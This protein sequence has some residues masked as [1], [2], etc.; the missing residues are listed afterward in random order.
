MWLSFIKP[1]PAYFCN[2]LSCTKEYQLRSLGFEKDQIE[3]YDIEQL[4]MA[5]QRIDDCISKPEAFGVFKYKIRSRTFYPS[6]D[7]EAFEIGIL[8]IFYERKQLILERIRLIKNSE[9]KVDNL[10]DLVE[11]L[12]NEEAKAKL[13]SEIDK[14]EAAQFESQKLQAEQNK[15]VIEQS[16]EDE[17]LKSE[18]NK[19]T[20]FKERS[21]IWL[22]FLERE[23]VAT[24]VGAVLLIII[25]ITQIVA[26]F[27]KIPT[28][29]ILNNSFLVILGYFFGQAVSQRSEP[30]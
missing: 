1:L 27:S 29:E 17:R 16:R 25:T 28:S 23:S 2:F 5:I 20:L 3:S 19:I 21:K 22:S 13:L 15:V 26:V 14:L 7:N 4:E 18:L 11:H 6:D 10:R 30:K 24:I 9:R 12:N 8:P